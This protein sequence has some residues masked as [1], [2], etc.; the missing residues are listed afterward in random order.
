MKS[1]W[2]DSTRVK[3]RRDN[4]IV[5]DLGG[6]TNN[7]EL[8]LNSPTTVVTGLLLSTVNFE[9]FQKGKVCLVREDRELSLI[10]RGVMLGHITFVPYSEPEMQITVY[11]DRVQDTYQEAMLKTFLTGFTVLASR[12]AKHE[13]D[14]KAIFDYEPDED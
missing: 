2:I 5:R 6:I 4:K 12:L 10:V 1:T 9:S 14:L 8:T 13:L 7:M 3:L 11:A